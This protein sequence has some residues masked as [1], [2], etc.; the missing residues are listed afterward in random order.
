VVPSA[1]AAAVNLPGAIKYPP[2]IVP[3]TL[4]TRGDSGINPNYLSTEA[5]A[6]ALM[7]EVGGTGV[8]E[9]SLDRF[10]VTYPADERRRIWDIVFKG[11]GVNVGLLFVNRNAKGVGSTGQW[12]LSKAEP[13]WT[14]DPPAPTGLDDTRT[15]RQLPLRPL[16]ANERFHAG[17]MDVGIERTDLKQAQDE[18]S[19]QF[20]AQDRVM[21]KAIYAA[22]VPG[23]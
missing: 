11:H 23:V 13:V 2:Y 5:D 8:V 22:L 6:R 16:L 14:A 15:P 10:P 19:G 18:A 3:G 7:L 1:E 21:L 17:L 9:E 12:D 4:A 20:T